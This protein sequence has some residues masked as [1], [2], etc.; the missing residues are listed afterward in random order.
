LFDVYERTEKL[1]GTVAVQGTQLTSVLCATS[2][3]HTKHKKNNEDPDNG[4]DCGRR[5]KLNR[6]LHLTSF[7]EDQSKTSIVSFTLLLFSSSP[8]LTQSKY[9]G[10]LTACSRSARKA[11]LQV[12]SGSRIDALQVSRKDSCGTLCSV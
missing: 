9:H 5:P 6:P 12:Q 3:V 8:E 7:V 11:A 2:R 1:L 4:A 10:R